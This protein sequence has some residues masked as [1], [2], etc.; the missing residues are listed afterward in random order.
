M[1]DIEG[2]LVAI[3]SELSAHWAFENFVPGEE[4][5]VVNAPHKSIFCMNIVNLRGGVGR[6]RINP[7]RYVAL[8]RSGS[9]PPM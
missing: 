3:T 1:P 6:G 4:A 7:R 2:Q 5:R 8:W 9:R